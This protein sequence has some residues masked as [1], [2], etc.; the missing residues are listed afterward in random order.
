MKLN[1]IIESITEDM[2]FDRT[3]LDTESLN[4]PS[5]Y[6][7]YYKMFLMEKITRRKL[8][9]EFSILYKEKWEYYLG[10][11]EH[12]VYQANPFDLKILKAD[13]SIYIDSDDEIINKKK[14]VDIQK[15]KVKYIE[16]MLSVI[17]NR[18]FQISNAIAFLK[19]TNGGI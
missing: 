11:A 19:F 7:K 1:E 3:Q 18:S 17:N 14:L 4:I 8:E 5:L 6:N 16:Q 2:N 13:V 15:D 9:D 12:S 10:K